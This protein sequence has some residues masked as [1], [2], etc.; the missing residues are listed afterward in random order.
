M[1][2]LVRPHS[3]CLTGDVSVPTVATAAN[4]WPR[5]PVINEKSARFSTC[6]AGRPRDRPGH[7]IKAYAL[8]EAGSDTVEANEQLAAGGRA[9]LQGCRRDPGEMGLEE[10][11]F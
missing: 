8:Q 11:A 1:L 7:K 5:A 3:E 10:S 6:A 9:P 4:S 2:P